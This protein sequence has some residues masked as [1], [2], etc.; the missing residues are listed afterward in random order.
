MIVNKHFISV[1]IPCYNQGQFI[2]ETV[3]SVLEQTYQNFEI[4]II[5]D[6]STDE[7]TKEKLSN[8]S[9][10][11]TKVIHTDNQGVASARNTGI[12]ASNGQ[13]ILPLDGDDKIHPDFLSEACAILDNNDNIG[14]VYSQ[15]EM[16]GDQAGLC[17]LP[18]F[19][20]EQI[21]KQNCIFCTA[22]FRKNDYDKTRGYD[23]QMFSLEDWDLWLSLIES[24]AGVYQ[25]P[26]VLFYYR[27]TNK[28][29]LRSRN[30][31]QIRH[32]NQQIFLNHTNL[33]A[34]HFHDPIN[35]YYENQSQARYIKYLR[36]RILQIQ[37]SMMYKTGELLIRPF[38]YIKHLIKPNTLHKD[39]KTISK[40]NEQ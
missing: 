12:R 28:S 11:R 9:K 17:K 5:N 26:R 37:N 19:P 39:F 36:D 16:F 13:Y 27:I 1:I 21:L 22:L 30:A 15:G 40:Y 24:G 4:I 35:L 14:I 6:G 23:P 31:D 34:N 32:L 8:Y 33:Y 3:D 25:I 20:L 7:F 2:D 29:K 10:P 38:R 18:E